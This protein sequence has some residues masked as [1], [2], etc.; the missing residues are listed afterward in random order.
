MI[1]FVK[2][3]DERFK[4]LNFHNGLNIVLA[5]RTA[6]ASEHQTRNGAGKSS[7]I[8][9]LHFLFGGSAPTT[10]MFR[11]PA[12][13]EHVYSTQIDLGKE[14]VHVARSGRIPNKL[15]L[16]ASLQRKS[17][18][19]GLPGLEIDAA[20]YEQWE[21]VG[22]EQWR[23]RL[24]RAWF[25]LK[26]DQPTHSPSMR[27]LLCYLIRREHDGGFH[28]PFDHSRMQQPWDR[29]VAISFLLDLDWSIP[30]DIENVR[31]EER[32][33]KA[34]QKAAGSAELGNVLGRSADLR[35]ELIVARDR[36]K[37]L[38]DTV[39]SFRVV[40]E[41]EALVAEADDLT[42]RLR[43]IR[44]E[45]TID[46]DL[47]QQMA[48]TRLSESPPDVEQLKRMWDQVNLVLPE[49]IYSTYDAVHEF[50][51]S[52]VRNRH[53]YLQRETELASERIHSRQAETTRLE[54]RKSDLMRILS[55]G[56]ALDEYAALQAEV[57][58]A[59]AQ[60]KQLEERYNLAQM[61]EGGKAKL[62]NRRAELS[63][64]LQGDHNDRRERLDRAISRFESFSSA[65]YEER[66]GYLV[67]D[68]TRNGPMFEVKIAG[69]ES[70]G[71][72]NMQ[73]LCFDFLIT[74]LLQERNIG[75]GFLVHDSHIFDGVDER[76]IAGALQLGAKLADEYGFQYIVTLN[77]DMVPKFPSGFDFDSYVNGDTL[78]DAIDTGGL[79]GFRFD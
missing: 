74:T 28:L 50:H 21:P 10:S 7:L 69:R 16:N 8:R 27:S 29:Q 15:Y 11:R 67:V 78:T 20:L 58:G 26:V 13:R 37:R 38:R 70:A 6:D 51:N 57:S 79:F 4:T 73:I 55:A 35:S 62:D 39:S 22:L 72:H 40:E 60:V 23:R 66:H 12:L 25:G 56:G 61:I 54:G 75:P 24:G 14:H 5:D 64:R 49:Q 71:I 47:I 48:Q 68:P 19:G 41:Y 2:S 31:V 34:L 65:L 33:L 17:D 52:V 30:R 1:R 44:N 36:A 77:S 43:E 42:R 59:E 76:Q 18:S 9:L 3:D 45:D 46:R 63:V 32:N 53:L